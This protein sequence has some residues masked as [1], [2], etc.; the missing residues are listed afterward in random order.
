M[1]RHSF[2]QCEV[3]MLEHR[4]GKKFKDEKWQE[5]KEVVN[6]LGFKVRVTGGVFLTH[7]I[8]TSEEDFN[9]ILEIVA[10]VSI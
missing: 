7:E 1:K 5:F 3:L 2:N 6:T 8:N 9:I 10:N 4:I